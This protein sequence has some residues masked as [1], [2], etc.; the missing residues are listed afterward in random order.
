MSPETK[1]KSLAGVRP[2]KRSLLSEDWINERTEQ[3]GGTA[4][5]ILEAQTSTISLPLWIQMNSGLIAAHLARSGAVLF[6]GF[7]VDSVETFR[8]V[9]SCFEGEDID[10]RERSSPRTE[11]AHHIYTST[12][13]PADQS[14]FPHN[15]NSYAH[16]WPRRIFFYCLTPAREGGATP[17]VDVRSVYQCIDPDIRQRFEDAGVLYLRNFSEEVGMSWTKAF[18]TERRE[19][20]EEIARSAGYRLKWHD[21]NQLTTWRIGK[22]CGRHPSTGQPIWF[23]HAA[24]FHIST[25]PPAIRE[26][27]TA[28]L[29]EDELP[30]NSYY[31]DGSPIE[32]E[33]VEQIRSCYLAHRLIFDWHRGDVLAL[34]N[35]LVAHARQPYRGSRRV[36]VAMKDPFQ[37]ELFDSFKGKNDGL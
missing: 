22:A 32:E 2:R 3:S 15:E 27:L 24:F 8:E 31:G 23:N 16:V 13:Y 6:R 17:I 18:Q 19:K 10:Y 4:L 20:V 30:N 33:V 11:V 5:T 36:L 1:H 25:L 9:V 26:T 29:A 34:D 7:A 37:S 35:M 28:Q 14:I 12:E 21:N